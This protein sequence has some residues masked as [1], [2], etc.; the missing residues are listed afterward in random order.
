MKSILII[1]AA[2][3][4]SQSFALDCESQ[5]IV[6]EYKPRYA[7]LFSITYYKDFKIVNSE[8]DRFIVKDNKKLD[9]ASKLP[10]LSPMSKD[11]LQL[12]RLISHF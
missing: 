9:C 6:N 10:I 4:S 5:K 7:K 3:L 8:N 2:L 11:S 12:Q 1:F